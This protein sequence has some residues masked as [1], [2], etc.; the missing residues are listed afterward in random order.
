[1]LTSVLDMTLP[2]TQLLQSKS[3]DICDGLHLIEPL[4]ALV[5]TR[6]QDVDEFHSK[7][8]KKA[9]TLSDK[10]NITE[11]MPRVVGIQIHR[12]NTPTESASGYYKRTI[13]IPL[14]ELDYRFDSSKTEAVFNG[15]IIVPAKLIATVQQ[16]EKSNW[17]EKFSSFAKFIRDNL[18]NALSLDSKLELCETYC[19]VIRDLYQ[20]MYQTI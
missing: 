7:G 11:T 13:T 16:P 8:Y 9:L 17:K 19:L 15:F 12:S 2:V 20:L 14:C 3:I 4:K 10:I 18:P 5:I 1:M 6:R